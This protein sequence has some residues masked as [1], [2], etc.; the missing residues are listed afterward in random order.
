M[1]LRKIVG[2]LVVSVISLAAHAQITPTGDHYAARPTDTGFSGIVSSSGG[3]STSV[4]LDLP[5]ARGELPIPLQIVYEGSH[6]GA[7]GVGWDVPLSYIF[8][9]RTIAHRR[10]VAVGAAAAPQAREQLTVVLDDQTFVLVRNTANTAWLGQ[11]NSAQLEVRDNGDGTMVLYDGEGRTYVFNAKGPTADSPLINGNLF[12]LTSIR[13]HGDNMIEMGY[14]ISTPTLV[15]GGSG[16]AISLKNI[17]YNLSNTTANCYKN[18][19]ILDYGAAASFPLSLSMLG[20]KVL[21]RTQTLARVIVSARDTCAATSSIPLRIYSFNYQ[22]DADTQLPRLTS[23]TMTGL[24]GTP[25]QSIALPIAT[26]TYGASAA[27]DGKLVYRKTQAIPLPVDEH[28]DLTGISTSVFSEGVAPLGAMIT[29][30]NLV[31]LNGDGRLDLLK[32]GAWMRNTPVSGGKSAFPAADAYTLPGS[33]LSQN[34]IGQIQQTAQAR[35]IVFG[36]TGQSQ[37]YIHHQLIDFN[38]DGRLDLLADGFSGPAIAAPGTWT[39]LLNTPDPSDPNKIVWVS[40]SISTAPLTQALI[41]A[42]YVGIGSD[43]ATAYLP[44]ATMTTTNDSLFNQCWKWDT[45]SNGVL[46]WILTIAGYSGPDDNRCAGPQGQLPSADGYA[47]I[48]GPKKT[49]TEWEVRDINGDG[50]PDFVYNASQMANVLG[51][52]TPPQVPGSFVGQF[53]E[54]RRTATSDIGGSRDVKALLNIAGVHLDTTIRAFSAPVTVE[55]GGLDG[56]GVGRW[57]VPFIAANAGIQDQVCG[58]ED[59]NGDGLPDRV[60]TPLFV[61]GA[62]FGVAALGTGDVNELFSSTA[63]IRLQGPLERVESDLVPKDNLGHTRPRVCPDPIPPSGTDATFPVQRTAGLRDLNGDGIP[64]YIGFNNATGAPAWSVYWGTGVGFVGP[65]PIGDSSNPEFELSLENVNCDGIHQLSSTT[66]GLYDLDGDGRPEVITFSGAQIFTGG[67]LVSDAQLNVYQLNAEP[68]PQNTGAGNVRST[69]NEGR[70][71]RIDNGYGAGAV[72]AYRSAK[73]DG[74][75]RHLVPFPEI[76]VTSVGTSD[77]LDSPL[78]TAEQYAYG[79]AGLIF[80]PTLDTFRFPGYQR[81]VQMRI[82]SEQVFPP[83]TEGKAAITDHYGLAAFDSSQDAKARLNRYLKAGKPQDVTV[84]SGVIGSDP[85]ALLSVNISNDSRRIEGTHYDWDTRLLTPGASSDEACL[86]MVF[87]YDFANSNS[88]SLGRDLCTE[89]GFTFQSS[90]ASFRGT[91][92][93]ES[94]G[95]STAVVRSRLDVTQVDD[96]GRTLAVKNYND[97]SSSNDDLM[98]TTA[99]ATPTGANERELNAVKSRVVTDFAGSQ[100]YSSELFEYDTL[101]VGSVSTGFLTSHTVSRIDLG[102]GIS[103]G[104]IREFDATYDSVGNPLTVTSRRDDG[105]TRRVTTTYDAFG[106]APVSTQTDATNANGTNIPR[107]SVAMTLDPVTLDVLSTT[108]VNGTQRGNIF[109]GFGRLVLSTL[110]PP[111]GAAGALSST[112]YVG[113]AMGEVGGRKVVNKLFT[114]PVAPSA[115]ATATGTT[116]T[117]FLDSLGREMRTEL[118]LGADYANQTLVVGLRSYDKLGRTQFEA[119]PYVLGQSTGGPYGTSQ[120]FNI[121]GTPSCTIRAFGAQSI[122]TSVNAVTDETA[123]RYPTCYKRYFENNKEIARVTDS[124]SLLNGSAQ[125]GVFQETYFDAKGLPQALVTYAGAGNSGGRGNSLDRV[126]SGYDVLGHL[127][128]MTRYQNP[129]PLNAMEPSIASN[130]ATTSW[131]YDSLGQVLEFDEPDSAAQLITYDNWGDVTQVQ[132]SDGTSSPATDR[133]SLTAYDALGRVTHREDQTNTIVDA[134]TV[135]NYL[136]DRPVTLSTRVNPTNVLGRLAQASSPTSDI[137]F[138]YDDFGRANANVF[139]DKP[140]DANGVYVEKMEFHGNGSTSALHLVLP[141]TGFKD[142]QVTYTYDSANRMRSAQYADGTTTQNLFTAST[143][144]A[145]GRIRQALYGAAQY[146]AAYADTGRRL[147]SDVKVSS[148]SGSSREI[149][150]EAPAGLMTAFDALGRERTRREIKNGATDATTLGWSYDNL[151]RLISSTRTPASTAFP[152]MQLTYDPLGNVLQHTAATGASGATLSYQT[153]DRDRICSVA[154][155]TGTP[156]TTCTVKYDGVG[157]ITEEPSRSNGVRQLTYLASGKVKRVTDGK[158]ND[159]Q[160]RYDAFGELQRLDLTSN[161]SPDTRHDRH[162]GGLIAK[163]DEVVSGVSRSVMTRA[164]PAPGLIATRHGPGGNWVFAFGEGRGNRFFTDQTGAFVQDVDYQ[165]YGESSTTCGSGSTTCAPASPAYTSA[166]WNGGDALAALGLSQLGAR[167]YDPVIGRFLSRDPLLLPSAAAK[168]NPYAFAMNDPVNG[169]DP[170]GLENRTFEAEL[171]SLCPE[172]DM[173]LAETIEIT[174]SWPLPEPVSEWSNSGRPDPFD[175]GFD[176][177]AEVSAQLAKL[178]PNRE[179]NLRSML[180]CETDKRAGMCAAVESWQEEREAQSL[181]ER[182]GEIAEIVGDVSGGFTS[183]RIRARAPHADTSSPAPSA[184]PTRAL[185]KS[186]LS[187]VT[188]GVPGN[189]AVYRSI[190]N[191]TGEIIYVGITND[192]PRRASQHERSRG[193]EIETMAE[194]LSYADARAVEQALIEVHGLGR[195]G[196]T[197]LNR[198]NSIAESNPVYAGQLSRG[199]DILKKNGY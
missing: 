52:N 26:Y 122:L 169:S 28:Q 156:S 87:P 153:T 3:Y 86:D 168:T 22:A 101:P 18:R 5:K 124:A 178:R 68:D 125:S 134:D 132:W 166:Q 81:S 157:N 53:Q 129:A 115:V 64:D 192:V 98:I 182:I 36:T 91:P 16:L 47:S 56:C 148:P 73:E 74:T 2:T 92:G 90:T 173:S 49:I 77:A 66:R 88:S 95:T 103:L 139:A 42:G 186:E 131:R 105:A 10:P 94:A 167:L 20:G 57:E 45:D 107:M 104:N 118:S 183:N 72:I 120:L 117:T 138:S 172:C 34:F 154:Y 15:G 146:T 140:A 155:G 185:R 147:L 54:T 114:D 67:Q 80:D 190:N 76:V 181:F 33:G 23:L 112:S 187:S 194:G 123:E 110:T 71:T 83:P 27:A 175:P 30:Q 78:M 75:T 24:N 158:G 198:I 35:A 85:W 136:Y 19:I 97:L 82:T 100:T 150:F 109:D 59:V 143:I 61:A 176:V 1:S 180:N 151:G 11:R 93:S 99:Y 162:Y 161:T 89:R 62:D 50:Y 130:P 7:A 41:A 14:S 111:G 184:H 102:T 160:F 69:P 37:G 113:F 142:E 39:V 70:L 63:K 55:V 119:D 32:A 58:F 135:N 195:D 121:D 193:I 152:N 199:Y 106:L 171:G 38:G 165:P 188:G 149:S 108:D 4:P 96:W 12:L 29:Q 163:R 46:R 159:A 44:L 116:S 145:L 144:D 13:G 43:P 197:L 6:V 8:R 25:E 191:K 133:R 137:S 164:I 48:D 79:N 196:G 128:S 21:A 126:L 40:R 17:V 84:L 170:T 179:L 65:I 174:V 9:D 31:D 51:P 177:Q 189:H 127:I 141:D 60:T